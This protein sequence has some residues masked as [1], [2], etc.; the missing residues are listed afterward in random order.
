M[1]SHSYIIDFN[2]IIEFQGRLVYFIQNKRYGMKIEIIFMEYVLCFY[3]YLML[4][5]KILGI[6]HELNKK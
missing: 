6:A 5:I 2:K 1:Y 4:L 3:L